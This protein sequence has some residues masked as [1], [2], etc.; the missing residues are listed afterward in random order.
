MVNAYTPE[1]SHKIEVEDIE[2]TP[3]NFSIEANTEQRKDLARR[4]DI[5]EVNKA[6]AKV[7]VMREA[8]SHVYY[9]SGTV[10]ADVTQE[11]VVTLKPVEN[12]IEDNFEAW[13]SQDEN[14]VML[15]RER[16][17]RR[18]LNANREVELLSESEDPEPILDGTI[19]IGEL[20]TQYLS[21]SLDP[22]PKREGAESE[23]TDEE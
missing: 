13:Y 7:M 8:K 5:L 22:Y 17:E 21:L 14:V 6:T 15:A 9:V 20:A 12:S 19:D 18:E 4:L 10:K 2:T 16:R 3:S 1:W 23:L 11:C